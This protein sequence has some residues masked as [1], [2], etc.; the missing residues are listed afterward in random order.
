MLFCIY[1]A[2]EW[3]WD[4]ITQQLN[5]AILSQILILLLQLSVWIKST[6]SE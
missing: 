3:I 5:K 6:D 4:Y 2:W 1:T